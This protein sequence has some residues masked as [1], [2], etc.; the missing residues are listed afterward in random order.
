MS[1]LIDPRKFPAFSQL[2]GQQKVRGALN[3]VTLAVVNGG[4]LPCF[5]FY[6]APGL[7]KSALSQSWA[8][9][10]ANQV[11]ANLPTYSNQ[12]V[13]AVAINCKGKWNIT[14]ESYK[15]L[16]T[17][18]YEALQGTG[19]RLLLILDEFGTKE[20]VGSAI[21]ALKAILSKAGGDSMGGETI[22]LPDGIATFSP[23]RLGIVVTTWAGDRIPADILSRFQQQ[24][25]FKLEDYYPEELG[26]ILK[27]A[28]ARQLRLESIA[29]DKVKLHPSAI[30]LL[31]RSMR[32]NAR[33]CDNPLA[34]SIARRIKARGGESYLL[35]KNE[36]KTLRDEAGLLPYG[37]S[38]L[39]RDILKHLHRALDTITGIKAA[40][41]AG[42]ESFAVAQR[43]LRFGHKGESCPFQL[44]KGDEI[45]EGA[46]G[47]LI[48]AHGAKWSLTNHGRKILSL[49]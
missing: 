41:G 10:L 46:H 8:C 25:S 9:D 35:D 29:P 3:E 19:P 27:L 34:K 16:C 12:R 23:H 32:G 30:M 39:E 17:L 44:M 5:G 26:D 33:Q 36:A 47:P 21:P 20:S 22:E 15:D 6:D 38:Q 49:L 37:I 45:I 18:I 42:N 48:Q 7:G 11:N 2:I 28:I 31:A 43:F 13:I 24:H 4:A 14:D 40:T 1:L